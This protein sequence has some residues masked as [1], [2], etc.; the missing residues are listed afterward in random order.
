MQLSYAEILLRRRNTNLSTVYDDSKEVEA[1]EACIKQ[2][3]VLL[4][5]LLGLL[6]N[7]TES[8]TR[9]L[10]TTFAQ[11]TRESETDE[12]LATR[13]MTHFSD[14]ADVIEDMNEIL[15]ELTKSQEHVKRFSDQ[16]SLLKCGTKQTLIDFDSWLCILL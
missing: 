15:L 5:Q 11:F 13:I 12:P 3:D 2:T 14:I 4:V 6:A 7:T 8:L 16:A 9:F 1:S 10:E